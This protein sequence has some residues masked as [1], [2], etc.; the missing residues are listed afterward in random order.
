MRADIFFYF[1]MVWVLMSFAGVHY[2]YF[3][4]FVC[5]GR[6]C[7]LM[8]DG[9]IHP[10]GHLEAVAGVWVHAFPYLHSPAALSGLL[11]SPLPLRNR[12]RQAAP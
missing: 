2:Y 3:Q 8:D 11:V 6:G 1:L 5:S 10:V 4:L 12:L 9:Q 7:G